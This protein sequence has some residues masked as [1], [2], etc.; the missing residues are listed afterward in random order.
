[1]PSEPRPVGLEPLE[2]LSLN[3]EG[4]NRGFPISSPRGS[5]AGAI[6]AKDWGPDMVIGS[7]RFGL[8]C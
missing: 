1:V 5:A 4:D 7:I 8:D 6:T 3:G 2:P